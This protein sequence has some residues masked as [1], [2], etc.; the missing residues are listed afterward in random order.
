MTAGQIRGW[1]DAIRPPLGLRDEVADLVI[2]AWAA[3][4]QRAWYQHGSS[5]AAPRPGGT[6]PD[7]ELRPEPLPAPGDWR[8]ATSRAETLFGIN[9]NPYLTAAGLTELST[10]IRSHADALAEAATSLVPRIEDA[11][12]HTGLAGD[13]KDRLATARAGA[14]LLRSLQRAGNQVRVIETLAHADLPATETAVANSL[15]Q[16]APVSRALGGF[17]VGSPRAAAGGRERA[18]RAGPGRRRDPD[19]P[20][21][22]T[23]GGRVRHPAGAGAVADRR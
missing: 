2:L 10:R 1:I 23:G 13:G 14:A 21:G 8:A 3:L 9:V 22:G 6:R 4:R 17:P 5:I 12:R 11:Y 19:R 15:H 7:M 16:A 18:G 20:A